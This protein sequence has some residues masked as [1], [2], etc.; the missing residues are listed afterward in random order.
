MSLFKGLQFGCVAWAAKSEGSGSSSQ[1]S[2]VRFVRCVRAL[3][4]P[5]VCEWCVQCG[6]AEMTSSYCSQTLNVALSS[7]TSQHN[8]P[9]PGIFSAL[10]NVSKRQFCFF[11]F[12]NK[13]ALFT[14]FKNFYLCQS[15]RSELAEVK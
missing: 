5:P 14:F 15:E 9:L 1:L 4:T 12:F 6:T 10:I 11:V 13:H 7:D 8:G 3:I 2:S